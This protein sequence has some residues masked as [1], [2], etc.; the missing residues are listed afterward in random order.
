MSSVNG[1]ITYKDAGVDIDAKERFMDSAKGAI[2]KSFTPGVLAGVG[3]FGGLFDPGCVG[4]EGT[5]SV[6]TADG[7]GTKAQVARPGQVSLGLQSSG[8]HT[9]GHSLARRIRFERLGLELVDRPKELDGRTVPD[10]L[11]A[12]HRPYLDVLWPLIEAGKLAG[13]AH[14]TGGGLPG[15][16][17]RVPGSCDAFIDRRTGT[18]PGLFQLLVRGGELDEDEA[19]RAFNMGGGMVLLVEPDLADEVER[20]LKSRGE[21][22]FHVGRTGPGS[23][24]V[25]W[26]DE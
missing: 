15:I 9:N 2:R 25:R 23:G 4:F 5:L 21:G 11:L 20:D 3:L 13:M 19:C 8:L 17:N 22:S 10:A 1:K 16:V 26:S 12:I 14:I 7:V 18:P 24:R 6:A